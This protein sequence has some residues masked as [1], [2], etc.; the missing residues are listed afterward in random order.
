MNREGENPEITEMMAEKL[1]LEVNE[2]A[3][4]G[5]TDK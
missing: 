5:F 3:G 4:Q 1:N 2:D